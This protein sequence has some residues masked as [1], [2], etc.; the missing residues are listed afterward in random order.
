MFETLKAAK[1]QHDR[2]KTAQRE[3]TVAFRAIG[4]NFMNLHPVVHRAVLKEAMATSPEQAVEFF[5]ELSSEIS[6]YEGV[7]DD[8]KAN[9]LLEI[10]RARDS[11]FEE[12]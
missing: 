5:V 11:K 7:S 2:A 9:V 10:Y 8:R 4:V 6:G 3:L 1:Q 12:N